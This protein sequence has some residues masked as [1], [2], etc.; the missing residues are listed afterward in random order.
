MG[1]WDEY[2]FNDNLKMSSCI[3]KMFII[4]NYHW[5]TNQ[6]DN[7][8]SYH[9]SKNARYQNVRKQWILIENG[10]KGKPLSL[11]HC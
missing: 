1:K 8:L 11:C 4:T 2:S 6:N 3:W 5:N 10:E 7:K 9:T